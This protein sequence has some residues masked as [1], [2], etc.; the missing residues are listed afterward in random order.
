MD[1]FFLAGI[2]FMWLFG[3]QYPGSVCLFGQRKRAEIFILAHFACKLI[4]KELDEVVCASHSAA[5]CHNVDR[6]TV[7]TC[8]KPMH[9]YVKI[10]CILMY[11]P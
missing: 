5:V 11:I 3:D 1:S 4:G 2:L 9:T 10:G 8:T 6:S 7:Y